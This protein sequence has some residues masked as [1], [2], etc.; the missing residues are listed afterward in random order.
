MR[1]CSPRLHPSFFS[2]GLVLLL[3]LILML[4]STAVHAQSASA[5]GR[6][7]G[8]VTDSSGAA[9]PAAG[10]PVRNQ[11]PGISATLQPGT[12]AAFSFLFLA[13]GT[14]QFSLGAGL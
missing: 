10:V 3:A 4:S 2:P 1:Q 5:T 11:N 8:T 14:Y 7:E 12:D 9:V 6:L 13:P